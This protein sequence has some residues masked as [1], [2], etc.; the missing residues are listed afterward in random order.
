MNASG[1]AF[2]AVGDTILGTNT[3]YYVAGTYDG[4]N[5]TIFLNGSLDAAPVNVSGASM[6]SGTTVLSVGA[7]DA[8]GSSGC[9]SSTT[10]NN[11]AGTIDEVRI[12]NSAISQAQIIDDM[13]N[14]VPPAPTPTP[15]PTPTPSS[16]PAPSPVPSPTP[17]PAGEPS[18]DCLDADEGYC[19]MV[20][21]DRRSYILWAKLE[22]ENDGEIYDKGGAKCSNFPPVDTNFNF[23]L[24]PDF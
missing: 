20:S 16:T 14:N 9:N 1:T 19:Y 10:I 21:S 6:F 23:C 15:T 3:W 22:N 7:R 13:N 24:K 17:S 12:Y 11:F 4:T 2:T 5:L 18:G 8:N